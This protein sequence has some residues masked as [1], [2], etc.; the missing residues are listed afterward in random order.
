[1]ASK[2]MEH[3][4]KQF[5]LAH[6]NMIHWQNVNM[7]KVFNINGKTEL[8]LGELTAKQ[9]QLLGI[10]YQLE[11]STVSALSYML[12]L[13]KS[14]ISIA[15][16]KLVHQGLLSSTPAGEGDDRRKTYYTL[17]P[18]GLET[19]KKADGEIANLLIP[20]L[21]SMEPERLRHLKN[22]LNEF[23]LFFQGEDKNL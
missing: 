5:M 22:A 18:K 9:Y 14:N 11:Q 13:S 3:L 7:C 16:A 2:E 17:T 12:C 15:V 10:I 21:E 8:M 23:N 1:M 4:L 19:L 20:Q 6:A